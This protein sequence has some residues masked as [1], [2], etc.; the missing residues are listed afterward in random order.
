[1]EQEKAWATRPYSLPGHTNQAA[2]YTGH[3]GIV[4]GKDSNGS[5]SAIAAHDRVVGPENKFQPGLATF[6]RYI[7]D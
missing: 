2:P 3:S 7:G 1:M 6:R 4:V 5:V